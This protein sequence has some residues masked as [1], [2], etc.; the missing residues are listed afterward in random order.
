MAEATALQK[1]NC[2]S[3]GA[4]AH[5]NPAKQALICAYCGTESPATLDKTAAGNVLKEHDLVAA[6][7]AIPDDRRGWQA[8]KTSVRCR[9][10]QAISVFDPTRVA[11]RCD[12]CGSSALVQHEELKDAFR[13]ESVLPFKVSEEQGRE[14]IR[15][16]YGHV[17]FAPTRLKRAAMTDTV[18]GVYLPYWTFDA[19]VTATW[20][21]EAGH[22]YYTTESYRD[23][24]GNR[25]TRQVRHVRWEPASGSLDH[26]FDDELVPA[27]RGVDTNLLR[28]VEPFPTKELVPY[29]P[30]FVAGWVVE[31]YQLDLVS[32]AR[33]SR[34]R[35]DEAVRQRCA[36]EVPGDTHRNLQV[37]ADYSRQTFKHLIVPIW[38]LSYMYGARRFQVVMNG[39]TGELAGEYPKSWIKI[40]AAVLAVLAVALFVIYAFD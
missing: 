28:A 9:S 22:Y 34:E 30:G 12:F 14:K 39:Y 36:A 33:H 24:K 26:V 17:W 3:C 18:H 13:P 38:L 35:M 6:L 11:Q 29:D 21:A 25:Q 2:P 40:A 37:Q 8:E 20:T 23:G 16:W 15:A 1:Y 10:C 31:R 4:E 5:W 32:A 27:S 7:R 19:K